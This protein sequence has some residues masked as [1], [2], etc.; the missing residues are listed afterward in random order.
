MRKFSA[1][2]GVTAFSVVA[3]IAGLL[4]FAFSRIQLSLYARSQF[5]FCEFY[6]ILRP[7]APPYRNQK[8]RFSRMR[9]AGC[10]ARYDFFANTPKQV[11]P[12]SVCKPMPECP[13]MARSRHPARVC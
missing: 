6:H 2:I 7:T 1:K 11:R 10:H 5:D 8:T 3:V 13:L 12:S 4:W 9:D